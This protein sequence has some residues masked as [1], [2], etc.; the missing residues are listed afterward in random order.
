MKEK[1]VFNF[2]L[3]EKQTQMPLLLNSYLEHILRK[4]YKAHFISNMLQKV[5]LVCSYVQDFFSVSHQARQKE[6]LSH[7]FTLDR[8]QVRTWRSMPLY[9]GRPKGNYDGNVDSF[10]LQELV[11]KGLEIIRSG[12][13]IS[14]SCRFQET[15]YYNKKKQYL[16]ALQ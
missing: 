8:K 5:Y 6:T 9:F 14:E 13:T 1:Q 12:R 7:W 15:Q 3:S 2:R 10:S 11:Q 16:G 4:L